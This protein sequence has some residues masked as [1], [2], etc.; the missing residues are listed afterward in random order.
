MQTAEGW[1]DNPEPATAPDTDRIYPTSTP[2]HWR[3]PPP[4]SQPHRQ[5]SR[6][7]WGSAPSA[8]C[9]GLA[10]LTKFDRPRSWPGT[11]S[12]NGSTR[13]D[14]VHDQ[15]PWSPR[16][17]L[18]AVESLLP[19][20]MTANLVEDAVRYRVTVSRAPVEPGGKAQIGA[21]PGQVRFSVSSASIVGVS[22]SRSA[23]RS[24]SSAPRR[25]PPRT[26]P[27][28]PARGE[29]RSVSTVGERRSHP[30]DQ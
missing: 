21:S 16:W 25:D 15:R 13:G 14:G 22:P 26:G 29:V 20:R 8:S 27:D 19:R 6:S 28:R 3:S 24:A 23:G 2:K 30:G 5:P 11:T 18:T 1:T 17:C 7:R 9:A 10:R 12:S 4:D